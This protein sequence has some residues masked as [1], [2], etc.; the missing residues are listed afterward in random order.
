M[1]RIANVGRRGGVHPSRRVRGLIRHRIEGVRAVKSVAVVGASGAVGEVMARLLE[2]SGTS[3]S[4]RSSSSPPNGAR[5]GSVEFAGKSIYPIERLSAEAFEGVDIVLSS[6]PAPRS[7]SEFSARWP[8]EP[9]QW[10]STTRAPFGWTRKF[11]WSYPRSTR[12]TM[13][14]PQGDHRQ[15]ELLD[16]PDGRRSQ[17]AC[18]TPSGSSGWSSAPTSRPP[19]P[20]RRGSDELWAQA[21]GD[22][23]PA[24]RSATLAFEVRPSDLAFNC[25]PSDRRLPAGR[26][27][28]RKR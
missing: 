4:V 19:E 25:V 14:R 16:D 13:A 28:P 6:T 17:A 2:E 23:S 18:T 5:E 26:V 24:M 27:T 3:R 21:R 15:P 10:W 22:A 11:P 12:R 7:R 1:V 20:A 8:P 9:A